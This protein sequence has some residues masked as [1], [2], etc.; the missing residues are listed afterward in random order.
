MRFPLDVVGGAAVALDAVGGI[1]WDEGV[2]VEVSGDEG[3]TFVRWSQVEER[4]DEP[5]SRGP[6]Q[7]SRE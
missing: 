5:P 7:S 4:V 1:Q 2:G 3:E 6:T